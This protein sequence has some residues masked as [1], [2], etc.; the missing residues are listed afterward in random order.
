MQPSIDSRVG[1][2]GDWKDHS[3][4]TAHSTQ[5]HTYPSLSTSLTQH[6]R[7]IDRRWWSSGWHRR[8]QSQMIRRSWVR[9][10]ALPRPWSLCYSSHTKM[11]PINLVALPSQWEGLFCSCCGKQLYVVLLVYVLAEV[12]VML[13]ND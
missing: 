3:Q 9:L 4:L 7:F 2:G 5:T 12:G 6:H 11:K 13:M 8:R 10:S 1:S